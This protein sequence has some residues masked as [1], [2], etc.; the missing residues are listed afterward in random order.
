MTPAVTQ[1]RPTSHSPHTS[2]SKVARSGHEFV[3]RGNDENWAGVECSRC[4]GDP[5]R[6]YVGQ[7]DFAPC[8]AEL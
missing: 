6:F 4:G 1:A 8:P 3:A 5:G 2:T 7:G